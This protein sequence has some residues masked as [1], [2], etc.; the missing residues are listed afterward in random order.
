MSGVRVRRGDPDDVVSALRVL[1]GALLDVAADDVRAGLADGRVYVA[2]DGPDGDEDGA[3]AGAA[4]VVGALLHEGGHVAAVAVPRHRR[5]EGIGRALVEAA[6]A[7]VAT[8]DDPLTADFDPGVRGFYEALGFE[9]R[10]SGDRLRGTW[11]PGG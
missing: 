3:S 1:E 5:G 8:S 10:E 2:V 7:D 6:A 9:I 11:T 4:P